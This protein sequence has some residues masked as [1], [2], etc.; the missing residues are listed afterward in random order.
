MQRKLFVK[1]LCLSAMILME[2]LV[3]TKGSIACQFDG[4]SLQKSG[5]DAPDVK[6]Y[7]DDHVATLELDYTPGNPWTPFD[8]GDDG[9]GAV[10]YRVI[11]WKSGSG[12]NKNTMVTSQRRVQI[13]PLINGA[14]YSVRVDYV[15]RFGALVGDHSSGKFSGG[16]GQRV[17]RLREEMTGFF[18]DFN[19]PAGLPDELKWNTSFSKINDPDLQAFFINPQFHTHTLVGTPAFGFGDRGQTVHRIRNPMR[20]ESGDVRRIVFDLDGALQRGRAI[21]YLDF[22]PEESEITSHFTAGGGSGFFGNPSSGIRFSLERQTAAVWTLNEAGEQILLQENRELE[23]S[24]VQL[25]PN[26]RR[27]MEIHLS[28]N[29]ATMF[30]DGIP[31]LDTDLKGQAALEPRDYTVQ[32]TAFAYNTMKVQMPYFLFHWDNFG[33]DGPAPEYVVHNYRSKIQGTDFVHSGGFSEETVSVEIPD[34]LTSPI[35]GVVGEARLVFTRQMKDWEYAKWSVADSVTVGGVEYLIPEP[36]SNTTPALPLESLVNV[37]AAYSTYIPLGTVGVN[38]TT[39]LIN[40]TN[41]VV[42]RAAGCGFHN[43]HIEVKY[44]RGTEPEY[45]PPQDIHFAPV[46]HHFPKVGLPARI[47]RIG[48]TA[49]DHSRWY[50]NEPENFNQSVSGVVDVGV[51]V[52]GREFY[53]P[54]TLWGDF[55]GSQM[56]A[57][58]KNP[59]IKKVELWLRPEGGNTS[60]AKLIGTVKTDRNVPAPQ[61]IHQFEFDTREFRN[62]VYELSVVAEDSL[63]VLSIPDYGSAGRQAG[64]PE[65]LNGFHFPMHVT[66]R[67]RKKVTSKEDLKS[68]F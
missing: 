22:L 64:L 15:N 32:W 63:G 9:L 27:A 6:V 48:N 16:D 4:F 42:F 47:T 39:P 53:G 26:V 67:N 61:F 19:R 60:S 54:T 10:G 65:L 25:F 23:F 41:D 20:L 33:F 13:Q 28:E 40:G 46:H 5:T 49:V 17:D 12:A 66:I 29:H 35:P 24:G 14:N 18:D 43:V 37:N 3:G 62:G 45:T 1:L 68:R 21:W 51:M 7:R 57:S 31:V 59:G 30:I 2:F 50:M 56:V 58:G 8:I 55:V 52:N 34:D 11:W 44:F 36:E 38:G